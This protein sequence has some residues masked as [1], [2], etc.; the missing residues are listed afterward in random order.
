MPNNLEE[1]SLLRQFLIL[2]LLILIGV[3]CSSRITSEP[4]NKDR[5]AQ[6]T[7]IAIGPILNETKNKNADRILA[8]LLFAELAST[9]KFRVLSQ[10]EAMQRVTEAKQN[11][12]TSLKKD[13][14]VT[15]AHTL[16]FDALLVGRVTQYEYFGSTEKK[17]GEATAGFQL[18]LWDFKGGDLLW[19]GEAKRKGFEMMTRN[20]NP[21]SRVAILAAR[22]LVS[23]ISR[24]SPSR[25]L[26]TILPCEKETEREDKEAAEE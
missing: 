4:F 17:Q 5:M 26:E 21:L 19:K 15:L 22:D 9:N 11:W 6:V 25:K 7:C 10:N 23:K 24:Y 14:L 20:R 12:P 2:S 8:D 18:E 16:S 1:F 13:Q 3:A